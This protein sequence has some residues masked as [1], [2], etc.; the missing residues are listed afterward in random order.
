MP[1][2]KKQQASRKVAGA[3]MIV[4]FRKAIINHKL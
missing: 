3:A 2:A 4:V 1:P